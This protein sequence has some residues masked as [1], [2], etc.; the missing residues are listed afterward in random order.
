MVTSS[1]KTFKTMRK[2][3]DTKGNPTLLK[4]SDKKWG[5]YKK[6]QSTDHMIWKIAMPLYRYLLK[7]EPK[8]KYVPFFQLWRNQELVYQ[9]SPKIAKRRLSL[10]NW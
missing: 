4:F 3:K 9:V 5:I 7:T 1:V 8:R 10:T 6:Y 2:F